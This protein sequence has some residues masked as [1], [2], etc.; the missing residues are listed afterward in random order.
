MA[1]VHPHKPRQADPDV[2]LAMVGQDPG[3]LVRYWPIWKPECQGQFKDVR[4]TSAP[5]ELGHGEWV[6]KLEGISGGVAVSHCALLPIGKHDRV[7]PARAQLERS[8]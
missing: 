6:V 3:F 8:L 4:T 1:F 7:G 2:L 5:W